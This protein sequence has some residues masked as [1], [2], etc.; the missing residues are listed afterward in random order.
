MPEWTDGDAWADLAIKVDC[1]LETALY[2]RV[3]AAGG[4]VDYSGGDAI[5]PADLAGHHA[6]ADM[7]KS[8]KALYINVH[9]GDVAYPHTTPRAPKVKPLHCAVETAATVNGSAGYPDQNAVHTDPPART[10][11][12]TS[13]PGSPQR[14][15]AAS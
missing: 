13:Q 5:L 10:I 2:R 3:E 4:W 6:V 12:T 8:A 7:I 14:P 11:A 1:P 9:V 15:V